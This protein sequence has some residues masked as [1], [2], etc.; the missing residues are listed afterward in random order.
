MQGLKLDQQAIEVLPFLINRIL[1]HESGG[2]VDGDTLK[3]FGSDG[4]ERRGDPFDV[5][6]SPPELQI[7]EFCGLREV[8]EKRP[9]RS[10]VRE[11]R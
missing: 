6:R 11:R 9:R 2:W 1:N 3:G 5:Q 7:F 4:L 8:K 10:C